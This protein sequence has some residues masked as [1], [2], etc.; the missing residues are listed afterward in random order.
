MRV[1]DSSNRIHLVAPLTFELL[2]NK[3]R[4]QLDSTTVK[5]SEMSAA[6]ISSLR[7]MGMAQMISI[8]RPD[9]RQIYVIYPDQKS[10][11]KIPLPEEEAAAATKTPNITKT[12][13]G[14]ENIESHPCVKHKVVIKGDKGKAVEATTWNATDMKGFPVQIRSVERGNISI[15][16]F[17][18]VHFVRPDVKKFEPPAGYTIYTNPMTLMQDAM[19][20][21]GRK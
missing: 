2:D 13:I 12:P 1:L 10:L 5:S 16:R 17:K 4:I 18:H 11:L 3:I 7:Q 9:T 6:A 19:K 21:N 14:K 20:E 15:V 8:I